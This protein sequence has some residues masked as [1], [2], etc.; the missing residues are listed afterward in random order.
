[1]TCLTDVHVRPQIHIDAPLSVS[2]VHIKADPDKQ[3]LIFIGRARHLSDL[4]MT[5]EE[6]EEASLLTCCRR[7][8]T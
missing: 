5:P 4:M 1:M 6:V 8:P 7:K 3:F 2:L